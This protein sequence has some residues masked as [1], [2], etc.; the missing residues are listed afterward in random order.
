[1]VRLLP[2]WTKLLCQLLPERV[3]S[4]IRAP[5]PPGHRP[6]TCTRTS[7][8]WYRP[9]W[10]GT[11]HPSYNADPS[12]EKECLRVRDSRS[13]TFLIRDGHC[14]GQRLPFDE[15]Q[16]VWLIAEN[17]VQFYDENGRMLTSVGARVAEQEAAQAVTGGL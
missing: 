11:R 13:T 17:V 7:C 3:S 10:I 2:C 14:V 4:F 12:G 9:L 16:T 1:M 8:T 5:R 6:N 15:V